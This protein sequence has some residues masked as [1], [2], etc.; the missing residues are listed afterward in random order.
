MEPV[1]V[2]VRLDPPVE[3]NGK[4]YAWACRNNATGRIWRK[5]YRVTQEAAERFC[6]RLNTD[7]LNDIE[8]CVHAHAAQRFSDRGY[9]H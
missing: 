6:Y 9:L 2:V 1:F 8:R 4:L 7:P 5:S 3:R